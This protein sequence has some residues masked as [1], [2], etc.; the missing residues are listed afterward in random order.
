LTTRYAPYA[1]WQSIMDV[2][3]LAQQPQER[4]WRTPEEIF[5]ERKDADLPLAGLHIALDPGHLGGKWAAVEGRHFRIA[6]DDFYICEGDLALEVATLVRDQLEDLGAVVTLLRES[7]VP[8]N[9]KSPVDYLALAAE[10]VPLP[11]ESSL[12]ATVAYGYA[13]RARALHLSII[14]GELV[15]RTRVVNEVIQPDALISLHINAAQWPKVSEREI[16]EEGKAA[17]QLV[18]SNHVH[19]LIFGCLSPKE[20]EKGKQQAQLAKKLTNASGATERRLGDALAT[21]LAEATGLPAAK[22]S[23][24]N[25]ILLDSDQPYLFARNLLMLRMSDCPTALL[26]PYVANGVQAYARLQSALA[27]RAAGEPLAEDD[28]LVEY[29]DAVVA[30]VLA[31]YGSE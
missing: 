11:K 6:E 28:I 23:G 5:L 21:A 9:P 16:Q 8:V 26:E 27:N 1:D 24:T 12:E 22:Y 2:E 3:V 18:Q 30:G 17:L 7:A 25:A 10:Q 4:Y 13:L 19:V 31:C 14:S 15:E 29:A 20:L